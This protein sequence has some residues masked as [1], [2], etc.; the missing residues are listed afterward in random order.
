MSIIV[1]ASWFTPLPD[2][3]LRIGIS[4]GVPRFGKIGKGYRMYRKLQPGPWFSSTDTATF[5]ELYYRE[6][7]G[8]LDPRQVHDQ[9]LRLADGRIPVLCCFERVGGPVWCHRSQAASWL[10]EALGQPVPELGH[11]DLPQHPLLPPNVLV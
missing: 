8:K 2:T 1:T 3:H 11:E 5:T 4:R 7:L 6:V 10:A 9:L